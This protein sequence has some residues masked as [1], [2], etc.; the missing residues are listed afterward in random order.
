VV[1]TAVLITVLALVELDLIVASIMLKVVLEVAMI[2]LILQTWRK[3]IVMFVK[4]L[5]IGIQP[6]QLNMTLEPI[7]LAVVMIQ[8]RIK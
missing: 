1:L 7:L 6:P 2:I 4:E 8:M 5:D 3:L